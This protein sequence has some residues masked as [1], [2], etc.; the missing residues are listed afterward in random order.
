MLM[1]HFQLSKKTD[2]YECTELCVCGELLAKFPQAKTGIHGS[3]ISASSI[4]QYS[5]L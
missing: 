5:L 4:I 2:N 1:Q 3:G